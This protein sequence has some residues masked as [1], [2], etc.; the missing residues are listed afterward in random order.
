ME[1][2]YQKLPALKGTLNPLFLTVGTVVGL[3]V[4]QQ[5]RPAGVLVFFQLES[6][7]ASHT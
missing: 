5:M 3:R 7:I 6:W 1:N 2:K 4:I